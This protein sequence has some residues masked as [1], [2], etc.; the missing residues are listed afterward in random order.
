MKLPGWTVVVLVGRQLPGTV[1]V[2]VGRQFPSTVAVL[3]GRQLPGTV[4]VL[5]V[6]RQ[7][8]MDMLHLD[9]V[10][11]KLA[12]LGRLVGV[13]EILGPCKK[14]IHITSGRLIYN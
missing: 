6:R 9:Q 10:P 4:A 13:L 2:L 1:A 11:V 8:N 3:V 7:L 12:M 5:V 14:H